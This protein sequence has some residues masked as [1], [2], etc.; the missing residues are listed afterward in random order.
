MQHPEIVD[1]AVIGK[2]DED[3]GELPYAFIVK[4]SNSTLTEVDVHSFLN[5]RISPFKR[6][7]GGISFVDSIPKSPT[8]KV[9]RRI[10]RTQLE[11]NT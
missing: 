2:L 6:L 3:S 11:N 7:T 1:A 9:L 5:S 4:R 10:L 8:G